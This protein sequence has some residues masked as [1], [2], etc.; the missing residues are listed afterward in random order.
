MV[1]SFVPIFG[2]IF[3]T[4]GEFMYVT[5]LSFAIEKRFRSVPSESEFREQMKPKGIDVQDGVVR[6][7]SG[8]SGEAKEGVFDMILRWGGENGKKF[9]G[10]SDF[11][12]CL[13]GVKGN[14]LKHFDR[15]DFS[16]PCECLVCRK[17]D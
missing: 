9:T 1:H 3:E 11:D 12:S 8:F 17:H 7:I 5:L 15:K 4:M 6:G 16:A 10:E 2:E 13:S 14:L